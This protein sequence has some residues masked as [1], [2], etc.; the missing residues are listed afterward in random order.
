MAGLNQMGAFGNQSGGQLNG[1]GCHT[2]DQH[3]KV[4]GQL[5]NIGDGQSGAL[6]GHENGFF[7]Q[8]LNSGGQ[9][10]A[11]DGHQN[12]FFTQL[13]NSGGEGF[14]Q[15]SKGDDGFSQF[16]KDLLSPFSM[17]KS[18][19]HVQ[20]K[21][22]VHEKEQELAPYSVPWPANK[23]IGSDHQTEL[24]ILKPNSSPSTI[25]LRT[26]DDETP[27]S[28]LDLPQVD[29]EPTNVV[30]LSQSSQTSATKIYDTNNR[31]RVKVRSVLWKALKKE[32]LMLKKRHGNI[33][34]TILDNVFYHEQDVRFDGED[35]LDWCYQKE[36]GSAHMLIFIKYLS[37]LCKKDGISGMYGF[38][39]SSYISPL[40]PTSQQD[41]SE[42]LCR[43][44]G[45]NG[46]KNINQLFFAPFHG[47]RHWMLAAISPWND[48]VFW[49]DPSRDDFISEFAQR[50]I[51]E[52]IIKF[53]ILHRK[54]I[55]KMKKNPE[56]RWKKIQ[57]LAEIFNTYS[58]ESLD[59]LR[60]VWVEYFLSQISD[61]EEDDSEDI[62][63]MD[64]H[65][66]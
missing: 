54:D 29:K 37:E 46:G 66:A 36:I 50:I 17:S 47:N 14:S 4:I 5:G 55:K 33:I 34:I 31:N 12:G 6:V 52:G 15:W 11:L 10:G 19:P 62:D 24:H 3:N 57:Y 41:R 21:E 38:C 27:I 13:L 32:A 22:H 2:N 44:F 1:F 51:N 42:Y 65:R 56:I 60:D 45:C 58:Q 63:N 20:E 18:Q 28:V 49:L 25:L 16:S 26:M 64:V 53:S 59:E 61:E 23:V 35:L 9:L 30:S 48:A 43:V 39:D 8:L 7:T 40:N